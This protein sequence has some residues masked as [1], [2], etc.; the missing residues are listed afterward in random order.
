MKQRRV[1][2]TIHNENESSVEKILKKLKK[3]DIQNVVEKANEICEL[4]Q[5][6]RKAIHI[7]R[8]QNSHNSI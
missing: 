1:A 6:C 8:K 2:K 5:R 7:M 3:T 4:A